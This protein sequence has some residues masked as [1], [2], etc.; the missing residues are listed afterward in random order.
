[1][2]PTVV[3]QGTRQSDGLVTAQARVVALQEQLTAAER[4]KLDISTHVHD[5]ETLL[6]A[7]HPA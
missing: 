2:N 1:M 5:L 6:Q 4:E 3:S 7:W